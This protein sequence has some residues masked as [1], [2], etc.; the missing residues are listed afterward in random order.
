MSFK[1]GPLVDETF[2]KQWVR[3]MEDARFGIWE[4]EYHSTITNSVMISHEPP[5]FPLAEK[6]NKLYIQV[7][8]N[9]DGTGCILAGY[10]HKWCWMGEFTSFKEA[11]QALVPRVN[12]SIYKEILES[13]G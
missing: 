9:K 12:C 5:G 3:L 11:L 1:P 7:T 6:V 8:T 2:F 10:G 13:Y 4:T